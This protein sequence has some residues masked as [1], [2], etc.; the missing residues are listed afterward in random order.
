MDNLES[1]GRGS[2]S[3]ALRESA[4]PLQNRLDVLVSEELPHKF[5]CV[6]LSKVSSQREVTYLAVPA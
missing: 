3:L 2:A 1:L 4:Q 5:D 6:A